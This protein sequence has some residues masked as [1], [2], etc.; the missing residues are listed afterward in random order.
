MAFVFLD[1]AC[2]ARARKVTDHYRFSRQL[3]LPGTYGVVKLGYSKSEIQVR[4]MNPTP[5][6]ETCH[7]TCTSDAA[8]QY[9]DVVLFLI[10]ADEKLGVGYAVKCIDKRKLGLN[11]PTDFSEQTAKNIA[12]LGEEV[13]LLPSLP[14][15]PHLIAYK[16][17][18]EDEKTLYI[19]ME[20]AHGGMNCLKISL[21]CL[22]CSHLGPNDGCWSQANCFIASYNA[23]TKER[24]N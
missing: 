20:C 12:A 11:D 24:P 13:R 6:T 22:V 15:H 10:Q 23:K 7:R 17:C 16:D 9:R 14:P 8:P 21:Y 4:T 1:P 18:F 2:P 5:V 3:G 19:V